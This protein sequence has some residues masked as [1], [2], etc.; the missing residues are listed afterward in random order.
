M[1]DLDLLEQRLRAAAVAGK[2]IT[3]GA[4]LTFFERRVA[5]NN[6][7][8]L[9]RDIGRVTSRIEA[10]GGA[11]LACLVVRASDGLP[12]AGYFRALRD[13]GRYAGPDTGPEAAAFVAREQASAQCYAKRCAEGANGAPPPTRSTRPAHR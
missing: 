12:G 6:V 8:A 4:L 10:T 3:Y 7:R 11:D 13:A 1:I 2:P 5:P 9:C